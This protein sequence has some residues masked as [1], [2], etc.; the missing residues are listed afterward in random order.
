MQVPRGRGVPDSIPIR[1]P[2]YQRRNNERFRPKLGPLV[3]RSTLVNTL[4]SS[5]AELAKIPRPRQLKGGFW[6]PGYLGDF[7]TRFAN[8][9]PG[10]SLGL[11]RMLTIV[12]CGRLIVRCGCTS[13]CSSVQL[14]EVPWL[15]RLSRCIEPGNFIKVS[16]S[17]SETF[18][19]YPRR[20]GCLYHEAESASAAFLALY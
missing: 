16:H 2:W 5:G 10:V 19:E 12:R 8:S 7:E 1:G 14:N 11:F 3:H 6:Y 17:F 4:K 15:T 13:G 9:P 18:S 20:D